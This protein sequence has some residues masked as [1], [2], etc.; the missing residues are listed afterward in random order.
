MYATRAWKAIIFTEV[1]G[2][3]I[4]TKKGMEEKNNG[5]NDCAIIF[6]CWSHKQKINFHVIRMW[7]LKTCC[8]ENRNLQ[9]CVRCCITQ[10]H[11]SAVRWSRCASNKMF[12]YFS[13]YT[14]YIPFSV[15]W[16]HTF[17]LFIFDI[18]A[19]SKVKNVSELFLK[20][21]SSAFFYK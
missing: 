3:K 19:G 21:S 16:F 17:F 13:D 7:L 15:V 18:F 9:Q 10:T 11:M 4:T 8:F 6:T 14:L 5:V 1:A 2:K 12:N 20:Q